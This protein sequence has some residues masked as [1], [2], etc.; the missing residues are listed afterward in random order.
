M[1]TLSALKTETTQ[2]QIKLIEG[3]FT[4]SEAAGIINDVLQVKINFH[5]L[6]RLSIN[7]AD[8]S[9]ACEFDNGRIHEL[10]QAQEDAR[11]FLNEMRQQ[12]KK[13]TITST[14]NITI[15]G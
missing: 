3:K 7:E 5:K 6:N 4:A 9:N 8:M 14:I 1:E 12:G 2:Q 11:E 10:Y 13:L 15:D